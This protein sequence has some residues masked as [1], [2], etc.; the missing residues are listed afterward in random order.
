[1]SLFHS[2][3]IADPSAWRA[4]P[5]STDF[6]GSLF[7]RSAFV[8]LLCGYFLFCGYVVTHGSVDEAWQ[9]IASNGL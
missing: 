2:N 7:A 3:G 5:S 1:M 4:A 9:A 6:V 8:V